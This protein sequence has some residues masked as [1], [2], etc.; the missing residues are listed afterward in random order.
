MD[1]DM[2]TWIDS[3]L[4]RIM[5]ACDDEGLTGLWFEG[6]RHF[7]YGLDPDHERHDDMPVFAA[8]TAW[9]DAYFYAAQAACIW[10]LLI[11]PISFNGPS[12]TFNR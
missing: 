7:A 11:S 9:L 2:T 6:Q 10:G 3:P 12:C 4:G 5:L 1:A 8:A